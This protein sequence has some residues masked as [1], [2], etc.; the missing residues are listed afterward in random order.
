M[1][2]WLSF[3][4]EEGFRGVVVVGPADDFL[5]AVMLTHAHHL[6]PGGQVVGFEIPAWA[7]EQIP[8]I[9]RFKVLSASEARALDAGL[10][11]PS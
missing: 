3:A 1:W 9:D 4:A 8:A 6:S 11:E 5:S 7:L 2:W 10:V